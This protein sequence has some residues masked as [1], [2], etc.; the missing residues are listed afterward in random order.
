MIAYVRQRNAD[1]ISASLVVVDPKSAEKAVN[2][3]RSVM[4]PEEKLDNL[5]YMKKAKDVFEK[6]R[7]I[8]MRIK[9]S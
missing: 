5:N 9:P 4:F 6:L 2:Q 1:F 8:D 3:L 7:N